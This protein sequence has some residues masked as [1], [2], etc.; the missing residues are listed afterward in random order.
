MKNMAYFVGKIPNF[1]LIVMA[2]VAGISFLKCLSASYVL[3]IIFL[4]LVA[5]VIVLWKWMEK[6]NLK[7]L[8][9]QPN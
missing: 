7:K 8:L 3:V 2:V 5:T 1:F 9:N 6:R 4:L